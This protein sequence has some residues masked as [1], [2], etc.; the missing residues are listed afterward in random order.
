MSWEKKKVE[1]REFQNQGGVK[2][3]TKGGQFMTEVHILGGSW[4]MNH[5]CRVKHKTNLQEFSY[6]LSGTA[7]NLSF[8]I[9]NMRLLTAA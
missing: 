1:S 6:P 8:T 4:Q 7:R 2:A 5:S 3:D 9:V